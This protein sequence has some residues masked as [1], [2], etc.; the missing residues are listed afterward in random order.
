ML[1]MKYVI[2]FSGSERVSRFFMR[3]SIAGDFILINA[4]DGRSLPFSLAR[5]AFSQAFIDHQLKAKSRSWIMGTLGCMLSHIKAIEQAQRDNLDYVLIAEDDAQFRSCPDIFFELAAREGFDVIYLNDRMYPGNS[6]LDRP[7]EIIRLT[8]SNL[9]GTGA[10]GYILSRRAMQSL[11]D[12]FTTGFADRM[13][14]GY[15]AFLQS[16]AISKNDRVDEPHGKGLLKRLAANMPSGQSTASPKG[17][18]IRKPGGKTLL[19]WTAYRD[20]ALKVG[21]ALPTIVM[22]SDNNKSIIC[23]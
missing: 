11:L 5:Q 23:S 7:T 14:A 8:A 15:D 20:M 1:T 12:Q 10:E 3:N 9:R 13:P 4:I 6:K 22:H 21:I 17:E 2:G 16:T 19:K 18:V